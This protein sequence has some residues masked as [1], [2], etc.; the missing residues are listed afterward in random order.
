M[1]HPI[2]KTVLSVSVLLSAA[3][4]GL[5][6]WSYELPQQ[7]TYQSRTGRI[8][9]VI[10]TD[11]ELLLGYQAPG[12]GASLLSEGLSHNS[13]ASSSP[14]RFADN[15]DF[16]CPTGLLFRN[17]NLDRIRIGDRQFCGIAWQS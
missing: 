9:S 3:S 4:A 15:L 12:W 13:Y 6:A 1:K 16:L 11:G 5:W 7:I 2:R 14:F 8:V 17:V 10:F